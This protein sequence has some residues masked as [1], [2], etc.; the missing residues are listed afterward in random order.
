MKDGA[1]DH[2]CLDMEGTFAGLKGQVLEFWHDDFDRN[3]LF[4]DLESHV[5]TVTRCLKEQS[6][7]EREEFWT[8]DDGCIARHN[9]GYPKRITLE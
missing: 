9:A 4:P 7:E 8:I 3:V 6:C 1:G 2:L 5:E